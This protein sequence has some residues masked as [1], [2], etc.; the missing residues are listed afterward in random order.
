MKR[1][2]T[3]A[4]LLASSAAAA[5]AMP[6][7]ISAQYRVTSAGVIVGRVSELFIRKGD[8]YTINSTTRS[9][10]ALKVILDDSVTLQSAGKVGPAGLLPLTF[11]QH[12]AKDSSRDIKA[13]FDWDKG[14]MYSQ[15]KGE[16]SEVKLPADTQDRI[17]VM[18]Q[19]MNIPGVGDRVSMNMSNGR[20]VERYRYRFVEEA[21][22]KTPA[23]EFDTLHYERVT[24]SPKDARTDVWLAKER[25]NLP[26]RVVFDD[27]RG[28]K[29]EQ[30]LVELR[31]R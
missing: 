9:D 23:G 4:L 2:L 30:T 21:R 6:L 3:V 11:G 10:G 17:S 28:V 13:T 29:L 18:Y 7:E 31:M 20:K 22:I 27:P 5:A 14:L 16:R 8:T 1:L 24:E 26:V 12:R 15:F 19:F 25:F